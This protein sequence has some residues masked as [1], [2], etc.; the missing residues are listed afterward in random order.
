MMMSQTEVLKTLQNLKKVYIE[1]EKP[2]V[3]IA[4]MMLYEQ[5]F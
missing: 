5:E 4:L 2:S 1:I 3:E